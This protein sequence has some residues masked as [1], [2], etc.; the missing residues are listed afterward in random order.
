[1]GPIGKLSLGWHMPSVH[2]QRDGSDS[3]SA[4]SAF[5]RSHQGSLS[6]FAKS[7]GFR[8]LELLYDGSPEWPWATPSLRAV[9]LD[10]QTAR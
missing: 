7:V 4:S 2:I 3:S 1:M 6:K 8:S 9:V 10:P 5:V